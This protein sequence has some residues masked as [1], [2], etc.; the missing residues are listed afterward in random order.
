M[1]VLE[2]FCNSERRIVQRI[3]GITQQP[4]ALDE[5]DIRDR[6]ALLSSLRRFQSDAVIHFAVL[7]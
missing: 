6:A 7:K 3:E 2:N 1:R 5:L 4:L